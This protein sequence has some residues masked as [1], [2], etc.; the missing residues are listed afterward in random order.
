MFDRIKKAI[1]QWILEKNP[2]EVVLY[3]PEVIEDRPSDASRN[4]S[5]GIPDH[6][7]HVGGMPEFSRE[8]EGFEIIP[9]IG[10]RIVRKRAILRLTPLGYI[11]EETQTLWQTPHGRIVPA[12]RIVEGG[13]CGLCENLVPCD[14]LVRC[15][16]GCVICRRCA[17]QLGSQTFCPIHAAAVLREL[18]RGTR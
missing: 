13:I 14:D 17:Y 9:Q 2:H 15:A 7:F 10:R 12:E 3:E 6:S 16:R 8:E 5:H 18:K 11:S 4:S 1:R